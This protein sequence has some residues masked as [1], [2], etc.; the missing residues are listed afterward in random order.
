VIPVINTD[1][2]YEIAIPNNTKDVFETLYLVGC[3]SVD[4]NNA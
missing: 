4:V 1:K 3:S 2:I